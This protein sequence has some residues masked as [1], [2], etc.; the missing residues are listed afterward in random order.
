MSRF[1]GE[2]EFIYWTRANGMLMARLNPD[3]SV[4]GVITT[5]V[6]QG[7]IIR[8]LDNFS[9]NDRWAYET[10]S[11]ALTAY[12]NWIDHIEV[13]DEPTGWIRHQP[14]NRRRAN[15]DPSQEVIRP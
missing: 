8:S 2:Q 3:D 13:M 11:G 12:M 14:S 1:A 6:N 10:V 4:I 5:I 7:Q 9:V 15:G